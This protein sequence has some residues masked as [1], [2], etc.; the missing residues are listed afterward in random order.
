[1]PGY[2]R[3]IDSTATQHDGTEGLVIN[4][5][6]ARR[7]LSLVALRIAAP[8]SRQIYYPCVPISK[9]LIIK[10]GPFAHLTEASTLSYLAKNTSLPVPRVHCAFIHKNQAVI[11]MERIQG[12]SVAKASASW[13]DADRA[14]IFEQ[15]RSMF[16][17][18]RSLSPPDAAIS[19]CI[20]GSL[21][22]SRIPRSWPRFGPFKTTQDFHRWLRHGLRPEDHP[23]RTNDQDWKDIKDMATKQD[24]PWPPPVFTHGDLN[25][26]NILVRGNRYPHYWEYTSVWYWARMWPWWQDY[27]AKFLDP[28]PEELAMEI[29]RQKWW[30]E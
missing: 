12:I 16:Q 22:D 23:E 21:C 2:I 26:T 4:D 30:G 7:W 18:L 9:H 24:G 6:F 5:D 11:V 29:T 14:A 10:S 17:E 15:L 20:G 8:F 13:S 28:H 27:I 3:P 25:P 19:S 1:M